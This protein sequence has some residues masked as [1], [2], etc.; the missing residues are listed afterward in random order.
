MQKPID[1]L[2]HYIKRTHRMAFRNL[3]FEPPRRRQVVLPRPHTP[4]RGS[5]AK[6]ETLLLVITILVS[7]SGVKRV[8]THAFL[9]LLY[10]HV[11][12]PFLCIIP[13]WY[14][15]MR[16]IIHPGLD[17]WTRMT[18]LLNIFLDIWHWNF[19]Y[20]VERP[21]WTDKQGRWNPVIRNAWALMNER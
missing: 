18:Y 16:W 14:L 5:V 11:I 4:Q 13:A 6:P 20:S 1:I 19:E 21:R 12:L 8:E 9:L 7:K 17:M 2:F 3:N 15:Y 10:F